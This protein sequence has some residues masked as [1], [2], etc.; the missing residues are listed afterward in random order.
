M[1]GAGVRIHR[2]SLDVGIIRGDFKKY[3]AK[4]GHGAKHV[5]LVHAGDAP[6]AVFGR[7]ASIARKLEGEPHDAIHS[8]AGDDH[9]VGHGVGAADSL[10]ARG[11][12]SLGVLA[13]HDVIDA[14]GRIARQGT[15]DARVEFHGPHVGEQVEPRSQNSSQK[16]RL[17]ALRRAD[18]RIP[19]R[20]FEDAVHLAARLYGFIADAFTVLGVPGGARF[21]FFEVQG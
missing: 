10:V 16:P 7:A 15:P 13:D 3:L 21:V 9:G 2:L 11:V 14:A 6:D 1:V 4:Q 8:R 5:A 19:D 20:R 12:E 17:G 18:G